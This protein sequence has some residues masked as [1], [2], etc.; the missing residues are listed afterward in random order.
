MLRNLTLAAPSQR[1]SPDEL[2]PVKPW[3]VRMMA[4]YSLPSAAYGHLQKHH[5]H[6]SQCPC[7]IIFASLDKTAEL[8]KSNT[9]A[10][11]APSPL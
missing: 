9:N 3:P 11:S 6:L 2:Y 1:D 7:S 4:P 8:E 5:P 10:I